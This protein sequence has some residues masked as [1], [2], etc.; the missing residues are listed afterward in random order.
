[1]RRKYILPLMIFAVGTLTA[2]KKSSLDRVPQDQ[3]SSETFWTSENE[4]RLA[5]NGLYAYLS[6]GYNYTYDDGASDNAYA[7]YPWESTATAVSAGNVDATIDMGYKTRYTAVRKFNYFLANV[8]KTPMAESLKKRYIAEAKV[9]RAF[10]YFELVKT[11]GP[12]PLLKDAYTDPATTG[13]APTA[14]AE[15]I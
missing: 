9:I 3:L 4:A 11:F 14:E 15:I 7:Q 5:L 8:D 13:V 1:M 10:A 2:C 12:V 6:S